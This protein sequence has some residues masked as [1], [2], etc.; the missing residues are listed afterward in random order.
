MIFDDHDV[1]D[2][3]NTSGPWRRMMHD[4]PWWHERIVG[5]LVS[6]WVFQHLGNLDPQ[7]LETDPLWRRVREHEG[8]V[9]PL[10]RDVAVRADEE[11][12]SF[13][14]SFSRDLEGTRLVAV[15]SR[16]GRMLDAG[17]RRMVD[18]AEWAWVREQAAGDHD[19]LL[20]ATSIPVFLGHALHWFEATDEA[21][22]EGA[23]GTA[24]ARAAEWVRQAADLEHWPA[25]QTSF[26]EM[27]DLIV[28]VA[29]GAHGRAPGSVVVLS[30][31]VHHAYVAEIAPPRSARAVSP[32][33][34]AVCSP[35]RNPLGPRE[36]RLMRATTNRG[37]FALWRLIGRLAGVGDPPVGWRMTHGPWFDNQLGWL[38]LE[39][40]EATLRLQRSVQ[41]PALQDVLDVEVRRAA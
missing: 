21:L 29:A 18:E 24:P 32:I 1:H 23:W 13:R 33:L 27:C 7:D 38:E 40:R 17:E 28:E 37:L 36:R 3:W 39:G 2:D 16:A 15:D 20:L 35:Y 14:W 5:G 11:P 12:E 8:D 25:F 19:H 41:G 22:A 26:R 10:L 30:G 4:K 9:M 6:Y 31:D 34:Q